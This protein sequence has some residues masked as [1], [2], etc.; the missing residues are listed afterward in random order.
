MAHDESKYMVH[1]GRL[2]NPDEIDQMRNKQNCSC[3]EQDA[4]REEEIF[5][6]TRIRQ[7]RAYLKLTWHLLSWRQTPSREGM[8][9]MK[10][11]SRR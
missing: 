9:G 2:M 6:P 8:G 10:T 3:R 5:R 4:R 11:R 7:T 1:G